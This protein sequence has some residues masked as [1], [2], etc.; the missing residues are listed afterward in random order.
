MS[1]SSSVSYHPA[2]PDPLLIVISGPSG[3]GKDS[4]IEEMKNR[5]LPFHFV[6]TATTRPPRPDEEH[7][8]DYFFV[9]TDRFE[10]MIENEE[11]IEH[12]V[13][14]EDYKGVPKSQVREGLKSGKHVVLRV[15]VQGAETIRNMVEGALLIFITTRNEEE[16][17]QRLKK[18]N[19]E[20]EES[21]QLRIDTARQELQQIEI[22]D[23]VIENREGKL[24][25]AVDVIEAI[26]VA[27]Q[28][29]VHQ[30][31]VEL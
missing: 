1:D 8:V 3:V 23:Y 12:A 7:G 11:L 20:S 13:V 5:R 21:L 16:L 17:I 22:F 28:H 6:V 2:P 18:R 27:E 14:Y 10:E 30:R 25:R 26:I 19:T 4:V 9:S 31:K 29:R 24:E 15:D